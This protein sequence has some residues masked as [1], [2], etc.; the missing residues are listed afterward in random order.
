MNALSIQDL[1]PRIHN[2]TRPL[3]KYLEALL[4]IFFAHL[5]SGDTFVVV[6]R[7]QIFDPAWKIC[8]S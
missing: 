1:F 4:A 8:N 6:V 7:P 2:I 3:S 5:P